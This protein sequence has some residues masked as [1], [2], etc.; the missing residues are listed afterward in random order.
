MRYLIFI[1][2]VGCQKIEMRL[3][4]SQNKSSVTRLLVFTGESNSGGRGANSDAT[5]GEVAAR[6]SVQI[7]NNNTSV[8]EN[9]D[10]GTNNLLGHTGLESFSSSEHS[11]EL[12]L[13]N[14]MQSNGQVQYLV[15][16]GQ[17]GSVLTEWNVGG[18]YWNTMVARVDAAIAASG[19]SNIVFWYTH[20]INDR[21]A[22][23]TT[24]T[25]KARVEAHI[26]N[27]RTEY[28]N[29]KILMTKHMT[30]NG[31]DVYNTVLQ[32]IADAD[33]LTDIV[34]VTGAGVQGDGNHYTYSGVKVIAN[35]LFNKMISNGW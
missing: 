17:G 13:A 4:H 30:N 10:V 28:P 34:E 31:N 24:G 16:T 5:S 21:I 6:S 2:L 1:L 29:C 15:K 19:I 25:F 12:E 8:F 22:G 35:N 23:T 18:S 3:F 14:I 26:T 32:D 9:L 7:W 11:W 27:L 33:A 20:G